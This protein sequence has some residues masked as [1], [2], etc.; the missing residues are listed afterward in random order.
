MLV[1]AE[2]VDGHVDAPVVAES[3]KLLDERLRVNVEE[4][5]GPVVTFVVDENVVEVDV[6][7]EMYG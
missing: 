6:I 5:D 2:A 1:P 3:M 7:V 4:L